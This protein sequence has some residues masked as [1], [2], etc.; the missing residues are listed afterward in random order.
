MQAVSGL[1][2]RSYYSCEL[3]KFLDADRGVILETMLGNDIFEP[4]KKQIA[5]WKEQI[6][7]LKDQLRDLGSGRIMFEY[8]IPRMGKR[9]DNVLIYSDFIFVMEFKVNKTM[10]QKQDEDQC[11]DYALDLKNF[12][13]AS[14]CASIV[15]ILVSTKAS[16]AD[17]AGIKRCNDGVYD[18]ARANKDGITC[19]IRHVSDE[20]PGCRI[21][22]SN[23]ERSGYSPTPMITEAATALCSN[24]S[25][26]DGITRSDDDARNLSVTVDTV[27]EIIEESKRDRA[28]S[29]CFITGVPGSGKTLA[30]LNVVCDR[31]NQEDERAVL[32]SG[33]PALVDVLRESLRKGVDCMEQYGGTAAAA[34]LVQHIPKFRDT[35]ADGRAPHE[36]IVVFDEAQRAWSAEK[37]SKNDRIKGRERQEKSDPELLIGAMDRHDNW[38][39]VVCLIG[40]GQEI[41]DGEV[42]LSGWIKAVKEGHPEWRVYH[43]SEIRNRAYLGGVVPELLDG[44]DHRTRA[45]LHLGVSI[46]SFRVKML[47]DLVR[48]V[49]DCRIERAQNIWKELAGRYPIVI[50][51][52]IGSAK[53]W[54]RDRARGTERY[55]IVASSGAKRLKPYGMYVRSKIEPTKWFLAGKDDLRSSYYMEDAATEFEIQGL[56]LDWVCLAWDA[57]LRY[58]NGGWSHHTFHGR[59]WR[60][61]RQERDRMHLVNAYRVLLTRARQGVVIF[62]PEGDDEDATR[63]SEFYDGTY[64][65]LR[66][67]GFD[68]IA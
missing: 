68:E 51:R 7:I 32:L 44:T 46:R 28:K 18:L 49:L 43:P 19:V 61:I 41:Y 29:I 33:N 12:H 58:D 17:P 6:D 36:R 10:Y 64:G 9:V 66:K 2:L 15:P 16:A 25:G 60:P 5:A 23:W 42:G 20:A 31:L 8:S 1:M 50:T 26:L 45:G 13:K 37:L 54:V 3:S 30:A 55:G 35:V 40:E 22:A 52:D 24:I 11:I 56:E 67:I 4:D 65:F 34:S 63:R 59:D 62:V 38:A 48:E 53:R 57:N 47:A 14:H 39:V 27:A 21:A